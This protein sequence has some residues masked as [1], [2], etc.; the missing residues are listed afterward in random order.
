MATRQL[1]VKMALLEPLCSEVRSGLMQLIK[2]FDLASEDS[3]VY[4]QLTESVHT[5]EY[6]L[7]APSEEQVDGVQLF[8]HDGNKALPIS[9]IISASLGRQQQ[10]LE[11]FAVLRSRVFESTVR[12]GASILIT[13][14]NY[15]RY[16]E[17]C[18]E[19]ALPVLALGGEI[20]IA[21][22][23]STDETPT[24]LN[25]YKGL[26]GVFVIENE[27]NLGSFRNWINAYSLSV[28]EFICFLCAD[29]YFGENFVQEVFPVIKSNIADVIYTGIRYI[30][31]NG[32]EIG[33]CEHP[34][35]PL[36][37]GISQRN[38]ARALLEF[39]N[40]CTPSA[41]FFRKK[42]LGD[43]SCH[44]S[45]HGASD[46]F[47]AIRVALAG[48]GFYFLSGNQANYRLHPAQH[49]RS[50][51]SGFEP[52]E[53][54]VSIL[55]NVLSSGVPNCLKGNEKPV[56]ELL[57]RRIA[58][59]GS[60]LPAVL[61]GRCQ[62]VLA[63]LGCSAPQFTVILTAFDRPR[64]LPDALLSVLN[65]TCHDFEVI[66]VNDG[67][68]LQEAVLDWV[69]RDPRITYIRQPNKGLSAARN[70]A[71]K[72]AR[73]LY[74]VYLDDDDIMLPHHLETLKTAHGLYPD[75]LV[76]TDAEF[77]EETL[78]RGVRQEVNRSTPFR[79]D[80]FDQ[81]RLQVTNYIPVNT[82]SYPRALL[83][84]V[85]YFDENL[86]CLEDW[87]MLIRL[88]RIV[89]FHHVNKVTV[90]VRIRQ[91]TKDRMTYRENAKLR[92]TYRHIYNKY[93]DMSIPA[94][95]VG[96]AAVLAA[97]HPR[98]ANIMYL[99]YNEWLEA[100]CIGE[101]EAEILAERMI[102]ARPAN[103]MM[104]LLMKVTA[105]K[106]NDV[107]VTLDS[108]QKQL[109]PFWRLILIAD[110]PVPDPMF[111][112]S[113]KLGWLEVDTVDDPQLFAQACNAVANELA[114]EWIG[115]FPAGI[116]CSPDWLLRC[117]DYTYSRSYLHA[118]Y[119][120]HDICL[121]PGVYKDPQLKPDFNLTYLLSW[122]YIGETVW[123]RQE[124]I[125]SIGG[126]QPFPGGEVY[127]LL[128]R[129]VDH[130]GEQ[131]VGHVPDPMLHL[132]PPAVTEMSLAS[133]QVAI[134]NHLV[135]GGSDWHVQAGLLPHTFR[136]VGPVRGMPLASIII[137]NRDK[138]E[139]LQ[140]CIESIFAKTRYTA[141]EIIIV[142]N[143][144][145]DPDTLAYYK[146]LTATHHA[147]VR[148]VYYN[149]L[150]NFSAQCNLGVLH[151]KGEYILLLN[152][153]VEIVQPEWL[154]RLIMHGQRSE[155]GIVGAKLIYPETSNIQH[156]GLVLGVGGRLNEVVGY[157]G[158][159]EPIGGAGYMNRWQCDIELSAVTAACL[160]VRR[161]V[162]Q[163]VGG[164]N[165]TLRINYND[166]DFCLRVRAAGF[167]VLWTPYA[168]AGH[169]HG[170]SIYSLMRD[171]RK[172]VETAEQQEADT[173]FMLETWLQ[174]LAN[175][176]S[177]NR[178]LTLF[179]DPLTIDNDA[180]F[181]LSAEFTERPRIAAMVPGSG[182][183]GLYQVN[184]PLDEL[185][186]V[187]YAQPC[188]YQG[189]RP[190]SVVEVARIKPD[191]LVLQN[192]L[193][194]RHLEA[195]PLYKRYLPAC[196]KVMLLDD[197][198]TAVPEYSSLNKDLMQCFRDSKRRI[199]QGLAS[200]D[201]AIV[202]TE[203][204]AEFVRPYL[205]DVIVVP[206]R[207]RR[208]TWDALTSQRGVGRK[209]RVGWV[210]AKQ[211]K[212]D[213]ELLR[214]V[215]IETADEVEWVL[216]G[217]WPEGLDSA[218]SEKVRPVPYEEYPQKLASLNLD[219]AVAPLVPHPFNESK[220]NLRLLEYGAMGWPVVCTDIEPYRTNSAPVKRVE[221]TKEAWLQA[222]RERVY[223][224]A[225]AYREGDV[226]K[227]WVR[228]HYFL[229]DH[230][231]EWKLAYKLV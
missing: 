17:Q 78:E 124:S 79:H 94:I 148:I 67:G 57:K 207:L 215:I 155:V 222:I 14:Y 114:G 227:D 199:Q 24:I 47:S 122:D 225:N 179:G 167:K 127:E 34:G 35:Y 75:S 175:D 91:N 149:N 162:Y 109:Y 168:V 89:P 126:V 133:R 70:T 166:V 171:P 81:V 116:E 105:D 160:L 205:D 136:V 42:L 159:N 25:R 191:V 3:A 180:P 202:S 189:G 1:T 120:D 84:K 2:L 118:F 194:D 138:L 129:V 170:T 224:L 146:E 60:S 93:D 39:D 217:E 135:R 48:G 123:F 45:F 210:G 102:K 147:K 73:G 144:S 66:L 7:I 130:Y 31:E 101:I 119:C 107:L 76:Y 221:N 29:D 140:P 161:S 20:I 139:F 195:L 229:E 49:T 193:T 157:Y 154:E 18:I 77:V 220:S 184:Q 153:D 16:I 228:Q 52:L 128:L 121:T 32:K 117:A 192:A 30:D 50:W 174:T 55:E 216:M 169:H 80:K 41:T 72:L 208:E 134:E 43:L 36:S 145:E 143:R 99:T 131:T 38:E 33:I 172:Q 65:Q 230:L 115:L 214:N 46:W 53:D 151:A 83:D 92:D 90:E 206:N 63:K 96:R 182:E 204:L 28:G 6:I 158:N 226:L 110:Y 21:D 137:P 88:S 197:L 164:F 142:D 212:G 58:A 113:D 108:L 112:G 98:N 64:L 95:R 132:P 71:L 219:L 8:V 62:R 26:K 56:A 176:P 13:S 61:H 51:G 177:Y 85:G 9:S 218:I 74:I 5:N 19:S 44:V 97:D 103:P 187:G 104:T 22:N 213:L 173:H 231:L 152:N 141:W 23:A 185:G 54:H 150:F 196:L 82:F 178:N 188:I 201:R 211:Y 100:H 37:A 106:I 190:L 4:I 87:D 68:D 86:T 186:K 15:G 156:A 40:F 27:K 11:I 165:E 111:Q 203:P 69:G 209:P 183:S 198:V 10:V 163:Q 59:T 12:P 200:V 223:D 125:L 181:I